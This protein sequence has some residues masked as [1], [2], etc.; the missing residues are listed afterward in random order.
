MQEDQ[1]LC[2]FV[3][4]KTQTRPSAFWELAVLMPL[5]LS[6]SVSICIHYQCLHPIM[7]LPLRETTA[8]VVRGVEGHCVHRAVNE[9]DASLTCS[10]LR[11]ISSPSETG[12]QCFSKGKKH[13]SFAWIYVPAVPRCRWLIYFKIECSLDKI[14]LFIRKANHKIK[15]DESVQ[16][17]PLDLMSRLVGVFGCSCC[18]TDGIS[19]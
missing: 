9:R 17:V 1:A 7:G 14:L 2:S 12:I 4:Y 3:L 6:V 8:S 18:R 16:H 15:S 19:V 10:P 5:L 11:F 13:I